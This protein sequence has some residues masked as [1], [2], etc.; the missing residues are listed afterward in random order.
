MKVS[1]ITTKNLQDY[2]R[3]DDDTFKD[4][5]DIYLKSAISYVCEHTGLIQNETKKELD[6]HE[7]ITMAVFVLVSDFYENHLYHQGGVGTEV[8][9]NKIVDTILNHHRVNLV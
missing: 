5:I 2:L 3:L 8:K 9:V 6:A 7:D 4:E 1:E